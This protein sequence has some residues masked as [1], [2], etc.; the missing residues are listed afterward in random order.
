MPLAPAAEVAA[1]P[2]VE[3]A[4]VPA[5]AA[6]VGVAAAGGAAAAWAAGSAFT[7]VPVATCPAPLADLRESLRADA[8]RYAR[9]FCEENVARSLQAVPASARR[10]HFALFISN[11]ARAVAFAQ[12]RKQRRRQ[13]RQRRRLLHLLLLCQ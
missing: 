12:Q 3:A 2:T 11:T 13:R 4:G 7:A 8:T 1:V 9:C 10:L 6:A 5:S